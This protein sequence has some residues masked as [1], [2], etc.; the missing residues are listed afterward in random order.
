MTKSSSIWTEESFGVVEEEEEGE[1]ERKEGQNP[2][3]VVTTHGQLVNTD[4]NMDRPTA[5]ESTVAVE[6]V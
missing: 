1:L 3:M 4:C 5:D 2:R 6:D